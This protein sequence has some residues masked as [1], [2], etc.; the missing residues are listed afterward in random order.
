MHRVYINGLPAPTRVD[1]SNN[2]IVH[3]TQTAATCT[4]VLGPNEPR[5]T[6]AVTLSFSAEFDKQ[7]AKAAKLWEEQ[8]KKEL[9]KNVLGPKK[10]RWR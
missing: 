1:A 7:V 2:G 9:K 8:H 3:V 4:V 10:A 5:T 6:G